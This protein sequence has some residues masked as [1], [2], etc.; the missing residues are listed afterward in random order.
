MLLKILM[1]CEKITTHCQQKPSL[2]VKI[3]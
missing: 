1:Q 2:I 3:S